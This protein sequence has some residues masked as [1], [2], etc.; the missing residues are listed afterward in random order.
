MECAIQNVMDSTSNKGIAFSFV[1][2]EYVYV[3]EHPYVDGLTPRVRASSKA[4]PELVRILN[5]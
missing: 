5:S 3:T 1:L 2:C 4:L